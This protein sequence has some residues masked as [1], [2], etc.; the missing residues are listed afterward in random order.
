MDEELVELSVLSEIIIS[1]E[2]SAYLN[3]VASR[4]IQRTK[5]YFAEKGLDIDVRLAGS[6]AK[7]TYLSDQDFDLFMLFPTDM[8]RKEME[9]IGL[10]AG[11]DIIDGEL[12][13]SEHPYMTGY[14]EGIETDMVPCYHL[15]STEHIVTAVDRTPFHTEYMN[16]HLS[17]DEKDQARLL[18]KF[19]KGIGAYGAEQDSRGFSGYMCEVLTVK[20]HT[21]KAVLEA[22]L[23]W[24]DG[25]TI[26]VEKAGPHMKSALV[27]YDPVDPKRN[28][29]SAVHK[30]TLHLFQ[31]AA[32]AY[33]DDPSERFFFPNEREPL[34]ID[35]LRSICEKKDTRLASVT[36][37]KPKNVVDDNLQAQLWRT[38]Y[39]LEKKFAENDF[40][41]VNAV[42]RMYDDKM[43]VVFE[44][45]SDMLSEDH[46]HKGP[47]TKSKNA[48]EDFLA[49]WK[50]NPMGEPFV[51]DG[52]WYVVSPRRIRSAT[53]FLETQTA[54]SG[55]GR[56]LDVSTM[57]VY[58]H[59]ATLETIDPSLL[60][61]LLDYRYPWDNRSA[62]YRQK[63]QLLDVANCFYMAD[64]WEYT[65]GL[66][67]SLVYLW[68]WEPLTPV[69]IRVGPLILV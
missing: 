60:T 45:E 7:G 39:G 47:P 65:V 24:K 15:K 61:E 48:S 44:L 11:R 31:T 42:H 3:G 62:R 67:A 66:W 26:V 2:E 22:A 43:Y 12:V 46:L 27:V 19:L 52:Y 53:D 56:S 23:E 36:F 55:I 6:F 1:K 57:K 58:G 50:G 54:N 5:D 32:R 37:D 21:F 18:K 30:D 13:Y 10:Q 33:L 69:Q 64:N 29:A 63:E 59:D 35:D 14:F 25:E 40:E 49:H 17:D 4:L 8:S 38:Q 16:S 51:K 41:V 9:K 28:A 34:G 20:Y 68:L